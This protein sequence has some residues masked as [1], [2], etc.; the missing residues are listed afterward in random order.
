METGLSKNQI[1]AEDSAEAKLTL[2]G[3]QT[4]YAGYEGR[5]VVPITYEHVVVFP[6][7]AG[8]CG[9]ALERDIP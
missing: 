1:F 3:L 5:V 8:P 9:N 2:E 4:R 7:L 6:G